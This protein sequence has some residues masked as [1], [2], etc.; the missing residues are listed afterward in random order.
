MVWK[1][2]KPKLITAGFSIFEKALTDNVLTVKF[3]IKK[4]RQR[5][6]DSLCNDFSFGGRIEFYYNIRLFKVKSK[7][8]AWWLR[9]V[10]AYVG[11]SWLK[12]AG[13]PL[14]KQYQLVFNTESAT[15]KVA[16]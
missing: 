7:G 8:K 3:D 1:W 13:L 12:E 4:K 15:G 9:Y 14:Q 2:L 10:K 16:Q 11:T 5:L 6:F